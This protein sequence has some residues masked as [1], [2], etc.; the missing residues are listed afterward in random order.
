VAFNGA[1][2]PQR[3]VN[4]VKPA[5][6]FWKPTSPLGRGLSGNIGCQDEVLDG[7]GAACTF[8]PLV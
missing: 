7:G 5:V 2:I 1:G 3:G 8:D 6:S 4:Q